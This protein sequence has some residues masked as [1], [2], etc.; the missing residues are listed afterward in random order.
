MQRREFLSRG[1]AALG[2]ITALAAGWQARILY[3]QE[4]GRWDGKTVKFLGWQGY[5][6]R[7]ALKPLTSQG[8]TVD[9]QY[10]T[11]ND[12]IVTKLRGGGL[13]S[14][15]V[16]TPGISAVAP[17]VR[18][19]L[20]A[21]LDYARLPHSEGYISRFRDLEWNRFEG[22]AYT[23][24]VV[25]SDYPMNYRA[26]LFDDLPASWLDLG[27][28]RY[29]GKLVTLDDSANLW[30]LAVALFGT[31][32]FSTLTK[33][34]LKEVVEAYRPIKENLVT[35]S[36]SYGDIVDILARGEA[37]A[38]VLGW[39]FVQVQLM[40]RGYDAGSH[41][42]QQD[43]TFLWCDSYCIPRNAPNLDAAYAFID[44]M[45]S[46]R[47]NAIVAAQTGSGITNAAA[48]DH[49]PEDQRKLYPY[50]ALTQFLNRNRF[51][52]APKLETDGDVA[53]LKDWIDAWETLKL[54]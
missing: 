13:G 26:D 9:A 16:V 27:D 51:Y 6:D 19:Q 1:T 24:P 54:G 11:N 38:S 50:D 48:I 31:S 4:Q 23:A 22:E 40:E 37:A 45:I 17:L 39:R 36:P 52:T 42:P 2:G 12:E 15:D 49:L 32:D 10:I 43:G 7:S 21:P 18:A 30:V 20:L 46:P 34:Q 25:W 33:A 35:I 53:T 47:G 14:I 3:G 41:V 29:K 8:L 5:D 28:P 44:T